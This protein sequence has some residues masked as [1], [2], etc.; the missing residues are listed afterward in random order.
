MKTFIFKTA[1]LLL[2][3]MIIG[4]S[5]VYS[6]GKIWPCFHG[7]DR[8]NISAET[9]LLNTWPASGPAIAWKATGIGEGYSSVAIADGLIYTAGKADNQTYI[10]AFDM[11]GKLIWKKPN[12]AAWDVEVSWA[13]SYKGPRSTPTYDKGVVYHLS[14]AGR[15]AAYKAKT[16]ELIWARELTKDFQ[17]EIPMY[18]Y[19][20]SVLVDGNNLYVRPAGK[21]A[22]QVCLDKMTGKTIWT[23]KE[24]PGECGYNSLVTCD[25]NG[26][27]QIIGASS[28]CF[29]S[30]DAKTG[31]LLW[32]FDYENQH[33]LNCTDVVTYSNYVF[34]TTVNKGC[35]LLKMAPSGTGISVQ[36]VWQNDQVMDC[37]HGGVLLHNGYVYGSG[38]STRSW[39]CIE[40]LTGKQMWKTTGTGS[41]TYADGMVYLYDEKGT[42]KLAKASQNGFEKAGEFKLPATG[43]GPYWAHPVV[44]GGKLFVRYDDN[45]FAYDIIKK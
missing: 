10:F 18:G 36:P 28:N 15:L 41:L 44:F 24:I 39:F 1:G 20:E 32:K 29:Y 17:A 31:K 5:A 40:L 8:Q 25:F 14:E 34:I 23:N 38:T 22:H 30:V 13:S 27:H 45:L 2:F 43:K 4:T 3:A 21:L 6:Q 35:A 33:S 11:N 42:L 19:S 12:G 26:I 37:Y 7:S 9:G 16:G